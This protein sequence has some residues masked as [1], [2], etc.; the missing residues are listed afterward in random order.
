MKFYKLY[1]TNT[2][3]YLDNR[4]YYGENWAKTGRVFKTLERIVDR[5]RWLVEDRKLNP[6]ICEQNPLSLPENWQIVEY[7]AAEVSRKPALDSVVGKG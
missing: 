4:G 3:R 1:D 6:I 2:H 7:A 5:V